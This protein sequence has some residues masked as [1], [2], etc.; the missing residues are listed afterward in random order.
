MVPPAQF[1]LQTD[2]I[3]RCGAPSRTYAIVLQ[4]EYEA[5]RP[6][7]SALFI[8]SSANLSAIYK[9]RF[10]KPPCRQKAH[11]HICNS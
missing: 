9:G 5:G 4:A 10:S 8:S 11:C 3:A 6:I 2:P 7:P 1:L